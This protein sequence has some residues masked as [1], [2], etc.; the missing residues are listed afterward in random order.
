MNNVGKVV[1]IRKDGMK[2]EQPEPSYQHPKIERFQPTPILH[3]LGTG[4]LCVC[5]VESVE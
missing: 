1:G 2:T 5:L 4:R 3:P